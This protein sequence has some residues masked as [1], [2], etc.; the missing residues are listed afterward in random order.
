M[1]VDIVKPA[2]I[3]HLEKGPVVRY[4]ASAGVVHEDVDFAQLFE[5][6]L[7]GDKCFFLHS[8]VAPSEPAS[9]AELFHFVRNRRQIAF[10]A[11]TDRN[12]GAF[13]RIGE[14]NRA[15]NASATAGNKRSFVL[16]T[17]RQLPFRRVESE[18][19]T[20]V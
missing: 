8:N 19:N 3:V 13:T 5:R 12:V 20:R 2:F 11:R 10:A 4:G 18:A 16:Q 15:P 14:R 7:D 17:H 9:S 1:N 6:T